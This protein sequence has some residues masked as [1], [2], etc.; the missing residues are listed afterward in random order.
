[1]FGLK[2]KTAPKKETVKKEATTASKPK[3]ASPTPTATKEGSGPV[4]KDIRILNIAANLERSITTS[5]VLSEDVAKAV[6]E[7]RELAR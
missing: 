3:A 5:A 7:L 1:M 2:K 4:T 6:K